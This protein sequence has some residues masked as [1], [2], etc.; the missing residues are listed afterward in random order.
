MNWKQEA[1]DHLQKY[2]AMLQAMENIPT[3]LSRLKLLSQG[4]GGAKA[5]SVKVKRTSAPADDRMINNFVK[6]QELERAYKNAKLW[7]T[8]IERALSVLDPDEKQILL[9]MYM[10]PQRGAVGDLCALLW[11]EQSSVYRKRDSALYRFTLAL[12]GAA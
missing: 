9:R 4:M 1:I 5:D 7:V 6:R 8:T 10:D 3:E 11:V 12:Y 2:D